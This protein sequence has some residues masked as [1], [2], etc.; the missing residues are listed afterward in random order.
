MINIIDFQQEVTPKEM[1]TNLFGYYVANR[2][3]EMAWETAELM[4]DSS[5]LEK[6]HY[7]GKIPGKD[8]IQ[9]QDVDAYKNVG[10]LQ[11]TTDQKDPFHIYKLNCKGINGKPSYIFKTSSKALELAI[12]V[13]EKS[14]PQGKISGMVFEHAYIDAMHSHFNGYKTIT[15]WTYHPGLMEAE[16]ENTES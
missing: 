6:L 10:K 1:E 9:E 7:T 3:I 4:D 2:Q 15:I 12:K 14:Q 8:H 11:A 5:T 13:D 16:K